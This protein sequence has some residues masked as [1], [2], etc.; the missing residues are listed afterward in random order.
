[1]EL[2]N[3]LIRT[4]NRPALFKRCLKSVTDQTYPNIRII[5]SVDREVNYI[6]DAIETIFV[7]A[8]RDLS[9]F[10][11]LYCN[12]L[13]QAVADGWFLFLDD[14]DYL[15]PDI[16]SKLTLDYP[17]LLYQYRRNHDLFP[18]NKY[19]D[20]EQIVLR[21][22]QVGMPCLLL[23]HSLKNAADIPGDGQGD[24]I[25]INAINQIRPLK[26]NP[27]VICMGDSRGHGNCS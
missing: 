8:D 9:C 13:K 2:I 20:G 17:A 15:M 10:Y 22:G 5:V 7:S 19:W 24:F 12:D 14:D 21:R 4:S 3:I 26:F 11:D 1:M 6:P 23:H 16:L 27:T 18:P 25:W